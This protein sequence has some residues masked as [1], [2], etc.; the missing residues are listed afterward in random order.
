MHLEF[1]R[2]WIGYRI[3]LK[4]ELNMQKMKTLPGVIILLSILLISCGKDRFT[5]E[6]QIEFKKFKPNIFYS[7]TTMNQVEKQP[8]IIFELRDGDGD[9][10]FSDEDTSKIVIKNVSTGKESQYKFPD[11]GGKTKDLQTDMEIGLF[12]VMGAIPKTLPRPYTDT[13]SFEVYVRDHAGH[14]SNV[15]HAAPFYYV[16]E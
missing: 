12:D 9:I 4:F 8:Y 2:Y 3:V 7:S 10:G 1:R 14:K 11:F 13:I 16:Q 15:I 5:V 6:P